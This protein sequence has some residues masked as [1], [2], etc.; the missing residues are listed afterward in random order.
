M[1]KDTMSPRERWRAVVNNETP[2][3]IPMHYRATAETSRKLQAHLGCATMGEVFER[4][5]IDCAV[6]VGPRYV[7]PPLP[8]DEDIYG[9]KFRP[10]EYDGGSYRECVS[11]PLAE[12]KTIAEIEKGYRW[13]SPDDYDYSDIP[14]K[15]EGQEAF[16]VKGPGSEPFLV[17]KHLR[18][19]EQAFIDLIENPELVHYC[20]DRLYGL[21]C[22]KARRT[23]EMA[24][25]RID[26]IGVS[27][28]MGAQ[29]RLLYSPAHLKEFFFPYM[30][31]MIAIAHEAG[32]VVD[33]H[34]D[35]SI[36]E[37]LPDLIEMGVRIINPVQWRCAGMAREGL[38]RDFGD[39]LIFEGGVDNQHTLPFG[40]VEEVRQEVRDNIRI[41]GAGGGYLLGPCHNI[42][43]VGP[44][45][46][47]VAMYETGYEEGQS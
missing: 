22:E 31:R 15:L 16:V 30:K 33:T 2:D 32:A 24:N 47:V 23:C 1:T 25:G 36:R 17:Y 45:E 34:S 29:E 44:A 43:V 27:E 10:V 38:K 19:D 11:H 14:A 9:R 13:P 6:G 18:G 41:L 3:R 35:G 12:Y 8:E 39:K 37:I 28:D 46:N 5:H 20:L 7:G 4:L 40:T 26:V 42:Q 21:C